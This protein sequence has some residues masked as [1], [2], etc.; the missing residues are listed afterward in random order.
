MG[1][2]RI[3][4]TSE[5]LL[6][7]HIPSLIEGGKGKSGM[8]FYR[9]IFAP[10]GKQPK[11]LEASQVPG[12]AR[13]WSHQIV[14][15]LSFAP[16]PHRSNLSLTPV[17]PRLWLACPTAPLGCPNPW[18][19]EQFMSLVDQ[20][21]IWARQRAHGLGPSMSRASGAAGCMGLGSSISREH[22]AL[23]LVSWTEPR[24]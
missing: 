7:A 19:K 13:M 14:S 8:P 15:A 23:P 1:E 5:T 17:V 9:I 16:R 6:H 10:V 12:S 11:I 24:E 22:Q 2:K 20:Q 3:A 18:S 4:G 21:L